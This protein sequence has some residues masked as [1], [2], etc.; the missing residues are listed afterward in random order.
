MF[1]QHLERALIDLCVLYC[2]GCLFFLFKKVNIT[3][4]YI[5]NLYD[6]FHDDI[7][8]SCRKI[9]KDVWLKM[10]S[11]WDGSPKMTYRCI[12]RAVRDVFDT[13]RINRYTSSKKEK[14]K[15]PQT[16]TVL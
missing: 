12:S 4:S 11:Q 16:A 1:F 7:D 6:L 13:V 8:Y 3:A 9:P 14:N 15:C 10:E 2:F 5:H